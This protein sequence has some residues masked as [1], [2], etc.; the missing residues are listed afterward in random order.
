M[1]TY[2]IIL[3]IV[4]GF[5]CSS[6]NHRFGFNAGST[7]SI[8]GMYVLQYAYMHMY[9]CSYIPGSLLLHYSIHNFVCSFLL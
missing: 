5:V 9:I 7:E 6:H 3:C 8:E 4:F 2:C 1:T